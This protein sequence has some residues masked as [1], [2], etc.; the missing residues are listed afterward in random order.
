LVEVSARA[1]SGVAG[2]VSNEALGKIVAERGNVTLVG[3]AVNQRGRVSATTS[4]G[5]KGSVR[6]LARYVPEGEAPSEL[7]VADKNALNGTRKLPQGSQGGRL[8]LAAG[9]T[10]EVLP[11]MDGK[12]TSTDD[13]TFNR[14]LVE[15]AGKTIE[16]GQAAKVLTP[17]GFIKATARAEA[18]SG[19]DWHFLPAATLADGSRIYVAPQARLDAGGVGARSFADWNAFVTTIG[20]S[21]RQLA[22][23][24]V[25]VSASRN[26]L[27]I[28]LV[29]DELKDSPLQRDG[30]LSR[31]KVWVDLRNE[32]P[33][34][35]AKDTWE[36]YQ[37]SIARGV[38]ER[39]LSSGDITLQSFGDVVITP[40][41]SLDVSGG[42]LRYTQ[43]TAHAS[44]LFAN[45]VAYDFATASADIIYDGMT[46]ITTKVHPKWGVT[47]TTDT[48]ISFT[49]PAY[50]EGND[51]GSVKLNSRSLYLGG[52]LKGGVSPGGVQRAKATLPKAGSLILGDVNPVDSGGASLVDY[53]LGDVDFVNQITALPAGFG[54]ETPLGE[55]LSATTQVDLGL[56]HASGMGNVQIY[57][58]QAIDLAAGLALNLPAGG[59]VSLAGRSVRVDGDISVPAG[60][61]ELNSRFINGLG[62][63]NVGT[64]IQVGKDAELSVRGLW[65]NDW[66]TSAISPSAIPTSALL[67]DGGSISMNSISHIRLEEGSLLDASAGAWLSAGGKIKG[68][69]GGQISLITNLG[70]AVG[71]E[72]DAPLILDG[73]LRAYGF[74]QGGSLKL[75]APPG[76]HRRGQ[77]RSGFAGVGCRNVRGRWFRQFRYCR[78]RWPERPA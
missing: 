14:S 61:I 66:L 72:I 78:P 6:L 77:R 51:A 9:S 58:N 39:S 56:I 46:G 75:T 24:G 11:D 26:Y 31:K 63:Y 67:T 18:G 21:D 19:Q 33:P 7:A 30:F 37:D 47:S 76:C 34:I 60:K 4:V 28:L 38:A 43:G 62:L 73:T 65:V 8:V 57:S 35:I 52:S 71:Q 49:A 59:S 41:A 68:G 45:G 64:G 40:G 2:T 25:E 23:T 44:Q 17:G 48:R 54:P 55:T 3:L 22:A 10:T 12:G 74:S 53:R 15:L 16:I 5:Q 32:A 50:T 36:R 20:E 70:Q 13:Q 1:E 42:V 29:G 27:E 69:K